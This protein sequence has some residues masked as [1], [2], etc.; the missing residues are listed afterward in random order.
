MSTA[1]TMPTSQPAANRN[2]S[3]GASEHMPV[4]V[5]CPSTLSPTFPSPGRFRGHFR[6]HFRGRGGFTLVELLVVISIIIIL[7]GLGVAG[8]SK[9]FQ[10]SEESKTRIVLAGLQSILE[11]YHAQTGVGFDD[12]ADIDQTIYDDPNGTDNGEDEPDFDDQ[13]AGFI[14]RV[15]KIEACRKM[16]V[17]LGKRGDIVIFDDDDGDDT[18]DDDPDLIETI[19]DPWGNT[20]VFLRASNSKH[21]DHDNPFFFSYGPDGEEGNRSASTTSDDYKEY[22]DNIYSHQLD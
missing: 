5:M 10:R 7:V 20:I 18:D 1:M 21:P 9:A 19:R 15:Q 17:S 6:G 16:L 11:E 22:E 13:M 12:D 3:P 2:A 8:M 4:H 14:A